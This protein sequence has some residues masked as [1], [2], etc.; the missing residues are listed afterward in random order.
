MRKDFKY[1]KYIQINSTDQITIPYAFQHTSMYNHH[2]LLHGNIA[3]ENNLFVDKRSKY[4]TSF[5]ILKIIRNNSNES[6]KI[7]QIPRVF[8][9]CPARLGSPEFVLTILVCIPLFEEYNMSMKNNNS[10]QSLWF[11]QN[12][13]IFTL[14]YQRNT[15]LPSSN[16]FPERSNAQITFFSSNNNRIG[17]KTNR[18]KRE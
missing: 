14:I 16:I 1:N 15:G 18:L 4:G 5:M 3:Y 12:I 11:T 2:R 6:G 10:I 13:S 7:Q 8:L 9:S 17:E